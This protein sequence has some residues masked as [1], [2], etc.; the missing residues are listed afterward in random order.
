MVSMDLN[1][2][3]KLWSKE[4][5]QLVMS[6]LMKYVDICIGSEEDTEMVLGFKPKGDNILQGKIDIEGYKDIFKRI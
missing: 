3:S 2:R 6:K 4:K 1:Y 5:A